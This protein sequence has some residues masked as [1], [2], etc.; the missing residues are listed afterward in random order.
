[1][2]RRFSIVVAAAANS[3]IGRAGQ[4][5]WRLPGD[6]AFFKRVT[7]QVTGAGRNAVIM[8]RK[9]WDSIPSK[10]RPLPGRLNIVISSQDSSQMYAF[11]QHLVLT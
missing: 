5:P 7:S 11:N 1:M 9:T 10:F 2:S 8:G 3:G 4:L 6:L